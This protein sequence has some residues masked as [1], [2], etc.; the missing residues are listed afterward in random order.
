[1]AKAE[2]DN[3]NLMLES[4]FLFETLKQHRKILESNISSE[5]KVNL[6]STNF[7]K[8]FKRIKDF[9]DSLTSYSKELEDII[10]E[11]Y[12]SHDIVTAP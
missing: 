7:E 4:K 2:L 3:Y 12:R 10:S 8:L 6:L 5:M 9:C 1:M 11:T